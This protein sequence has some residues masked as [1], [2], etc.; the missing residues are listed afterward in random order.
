MLLPTL[1]L[2]SFVFALV[3]VLHAQQE[4][5]PTPPP[6]A[7]ARSP[8][9]AT[10]AGAGMTEPKSE[11]I[12]L[13]SSVPGV[14]AQVHVVVGQTVARGEPLF[15]ID[16]RQLRADL[17]VKE[18]MLA[19][20]EAQLAKLEAMP[21]PEEIPPSEAKVREAKA[22]LVQAQDLVNRSRRLKAARA[23]GDEENVRTE[24]AYQAALEQLSQAESSHRLLLA[25]AWES[26]R[27]VAR[28]AAQQS[29][30][31]VDQLKIELDRLIVRAPSGGTILQ[32]NVRPGEF[33]GAP[34]S[35]A[36][37]VLGDLSTLHVRVD[38]DEHDIHRFRPQAV[39][40]GR[41]RGSQ[42]VEVPLEFV[43]VEPYVIPKKSLT[44]ANTERV[45]TR[46][47]QVIFAVKD[48]SIPLYVGQQLDVFIDL[49]PPQEAKAH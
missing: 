12:S 16:D 44:G 40:I 10:V 18:A 19:S 34:P 1:A 26:D 27:R 30:A 11:S 8:Y 47:L 25:G 24:Q 29:R 43:R 28:A 45:D 42:S 17:A 37:I 21:R 41:V 13:G 31:Q 36:L 49:S 33:V 35:Q 38:I 32:V 39:G 23:I 6:I 3:R 9:S 15:R 5:P 4:A 48:R 14:V 7:P 22:R 20:A 46:V 2:G